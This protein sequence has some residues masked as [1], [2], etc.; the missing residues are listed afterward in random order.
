M[1]KAGNNGTRA[2]LESV[3]LRAFW[4]P[5]LVFLVYVGACI[6][7][8]TTQ[9]PGIDMVFHLVGGFSIAYSV[10]RSLENLDASGMGRGLEGVLWPIF[11]VAMTATAAV[12]WEFAEFA[13]DSAFA[14][15]FQTDLP[16]TMSDMALGVVGGLIFLALHRVR[17]S[18]S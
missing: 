11:I 6:L 7:G 12:F 9:L 10:S 4:L 13:L 15:R 1:T 8:V 3:S 5:T 14:M 16:D 18:M 2:L 17:R